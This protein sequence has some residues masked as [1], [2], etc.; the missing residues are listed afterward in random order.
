MPATV[1]TVSEQPRMYLEP[2]Y[3]TESTRLSIVMAGSSPA[4]GK[5]Q[6]EM[7][8]NGHKWKVFYPFVEF[9]WDWRE[10]QSL[11]QGRRRLSNALAWCK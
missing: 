5:A 10:A 9:C 2:P 4:R 11:K 7:P 1:Q 8:G 6:G 3:Y